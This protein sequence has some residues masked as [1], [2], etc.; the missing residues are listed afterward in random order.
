VQ[1]R[2]IIRHTDVCGSA[3]IHRWK[4]ICCEDSNSAKRELFSHITFLQTQCHGSYWQDP[5]R[6]PGWLLIHGLQWEDGMVPYSMAK[7][8]ITMAIVDTEK[9]DDDDDEV[10]IYFIYEV[11]SKMWMAEGYVRKRSKKH[12]D[13]WNIGCRLQRYTIFNLNVNN[14]MRC[15]RYIKNYLCV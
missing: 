4:E 6:L 13:Y 2:K 5:E 11:F 3:M 1:S 15:G 10:F 14:T 7:H 8:L 12:H 9:N